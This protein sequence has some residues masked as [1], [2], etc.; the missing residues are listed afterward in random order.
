MA[1]LNEK[2]LLI[3]ALH[4]HFARHLKATKDMHSPPAVSTEEVFD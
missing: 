2:E 3:E 1:D 4:S